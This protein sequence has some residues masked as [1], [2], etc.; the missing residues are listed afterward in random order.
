MKVNVRR[1]P[2]DRMT[3]WL[4]GA[5]FVVESQLLLALDTA[6]PGAILVARRRS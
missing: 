6:L 2:A 5:G 1:R 3:S 4:D